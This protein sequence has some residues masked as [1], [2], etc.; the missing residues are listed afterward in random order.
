MRIVLGATILLTNT[1][2]AVALHTSL[3]GFHF[4]LIDWAFLTVYVLTALATSLSIVGYFLHKRGAPKAL[5]L[6]NLAG[7]IMHPVLVGLVS[8]GFV[9]A[10]V[11]LSQKIFVP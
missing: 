5:F 2:Y 4:R 3:L 8:V 1:I 7:R 6:V 9:L 10:Y 11:V